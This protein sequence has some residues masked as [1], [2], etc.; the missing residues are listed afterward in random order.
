FDEPR[1]MLA[2]FINSLLSK[3]GHMIQQWKVLIAVLGLM[4]MLLA[5][6]P[7]DESLLAASSKGD[8]GEVQTLLKREANVN[9]AN[10]EGTTPLFIAAEKGHRDIVALLLDKGADV[11]Q[12]RA[13]SGE[14]PLFI[15]AQEGHREIVALLLDHGADVKQTR[16]ENGATPLL[17]A[18][19]KGHREIVA[20]L[21]DHGADVKPTTTN[22]WTA[23]HVAAIAG[24]RE[25]V[26][27]L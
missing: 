9:A 16:T 13:D 21:L 20:L 8:L 11:K 6:R 15:A 19:A 3:E 24:N 7:V 22:G 18:A 14:P 27:L 12:E 1:T 26:A 23:L 25:I 4:P 10:E 5:M 17:I 2:G